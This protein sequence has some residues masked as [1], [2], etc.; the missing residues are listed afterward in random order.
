MWVPSRSIA[1]TGAG[2]LGPG[3]R[4]AEP[5]R[6]ETRETA[7]PEEKLLSQLGFYLDAKAF[8]NEPWVL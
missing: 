5:R 1:G 7:C 4:E 2:L 8:E 6:L 3:T